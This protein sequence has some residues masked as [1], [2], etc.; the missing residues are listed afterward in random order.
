MLLLLWQAVLRRDPL[1]GCR[2]S[3]A[4]EAN[5]FAKHDSFSNLIVVNPNQILCYTISFLLQ[6]K[7]IFI[8]YW[9]L[10]SLDLNLQTKT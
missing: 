7:I 8:L 4:R 3:D 5:P 10:S 6:Y 1:Q 9:V 2:P